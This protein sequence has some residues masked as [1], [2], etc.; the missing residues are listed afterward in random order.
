MTL[1]IHSPDELVAVIP[2]MLRFRPQ[3]SLVFVPMRSDLPVARVD[4][5]TTPRE[6]ELVWRSIR[7]GLTRYA[8][9]GAAVGIVCFTADR[10][11]ADLVGREFAERLD[12]IGIDTHLL[13]WADKTRWADLVTG[14]M[15]LQTD[16][17]RERVA[18]MTVLGGRTQPAASRTSLAESLVGDREPVARLLP[19]ARAS[20]RENTAKLEG[21]WANSRVQRFHRD[22]VKLSDADAARLLVAVESIPIRDRLWL[23]MARGNAASHVALW[24]DMTR[25]APDEVRAAPASLLAFGSW[26]SGHGAMAWCALDQVP[27]DRPYALANLV[28]AAVQGGMHPREWEAA[29]SLPAERRGIDRASDFAPFRQSGQVGPVRPAHG[30]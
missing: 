4:I 17:A 7:E 22:R 5:P 23:D 11:Q 20:G 9:P 30:I 27:R 18:A 19:E 3:E 10:Q 29:N 6:Q 2:H 24:T 28:A 13:L 12:T 16:A 14:D 21:R 1:S 25:R 26:L 15:G 8:Q